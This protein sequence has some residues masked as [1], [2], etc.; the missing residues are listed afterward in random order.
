MK[1][2]DFMLENPLEEMS[3]SEISNFLLSQGKKMHDS[4]VS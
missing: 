3:L 2:S 1:K 4:M